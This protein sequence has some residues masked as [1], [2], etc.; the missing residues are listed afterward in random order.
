MAAILLR[1]ARGAL[2]AAALFG[3]LGGFLSCGVNRGE[4]AILWTDQSEFAVY[5]EY[6]N[7]QHE[8]YKVEVRYFDSPAQKLAREEEYPDIVAGNWLKSAAARTFFVPLD[9]LFKN[10]T[11]NEAY[12]YPKL[13]ALGKIE[14]RQYLLPV[15]FNIPAMVFARDKEALISNPFTIDLEEIKKLGKEYNRESGGTYSR[16]GFS[17]AW[18]DEFLFV[19]AK[20]FNTAFREAAP[21]GWNSQALEDTLLYSRQWIAEANT[22]IQ[23]VDDFAFKYFYDPPAKRLISAH[24]LF[25]YMGSAELFT[26]A[27]EHRSGLDFRW[28]AEKN[29]IPLNEDT[30]YYGIC[31]KG[32]A[33]NAAEAFTRWFFQP[34]TQ[35]QFMESAQNKRINESSFGIG[36]GFSALRGVTEQVFPRFYPSLLGRIPPEDYLAPPNVLPRNWPAIK[37]KVLLPYLHE[38]IRLND[39]ES[40]SPPLEQRITNWIRLN[41][42]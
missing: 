42:E 31:K 14:N 16:M 10:Q 15:S 9:R 12:F 27:Q 7:S 24:I 5:A 18:N 6:F 35:T 33:R 38:R 1:K 28:I 25:A 11:L 30:V 41:R 32:K 3:V 8:F 20:L 17:P 26:M 2:C 19:T 21:L 40:I 29:T 34:E 22:G 36:G 23:Q 37:E 13:L 39:Q 4:P